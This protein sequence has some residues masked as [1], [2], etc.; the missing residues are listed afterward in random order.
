MLSTQFLL[1][2]TKPA[3]PNHSDINAAPLTRKMRDTLLTMFGSEVRPHAPGG[4]TDDVNYK[5]VLKYTH[6]IAVQET[7]RIQEDKEVLKTLSWKTRVTLAQLRSGHCSILNSFLAKINTTTYVDECPKCC[8]TPMIPHTHSHAQLILQISPQGSSG[9]IPQRQLPS[10]DWR[11]TER[12]DNWTTL[13]G[14]VLVS[15]IK[16]LEIIKELI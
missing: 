10:W 14:L 3:H 13:T 12:L 2:T 1:A 15:I 11:R 5:E 4:I 6:T 8:L 7:I 16:T 9:M